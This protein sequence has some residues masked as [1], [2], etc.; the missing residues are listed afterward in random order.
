[1]PLQV[2]LAFVVLFSGVSSNVLFEPKSDSSDVAGSEYADPYQD[3]PSAPAVQDAEFDPQIWMTDDE[4]ALFKKTISKATKYFEF[5]CGGS[6]REAAKLDVP[7][8]TS[9]DTSIEWLGIVKNLVGERGCFN[10]YD[11]DIGPTK[12]E[13]GMPIGAEWSHLW[14]LLPL[15]Y[16]VYGQ[17][18][19][20][21]LIDGR[22]RVAC[23]M[24][25]WLES[26]PT[27]TVMIHDYQREAYHVVEQFYNKV[28]QA[29]R[30][31]VLKPKADKMKDRKTRLLALAKLKEAQ[32]DRF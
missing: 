7:C 16:H 20:T 11:V 26:E 13:L 12:K 23:A 32:S 27:V 24:V 29:N 19:D 14:P 2:A 18:S 30:L 3:E 5:G 8:I 9:V 4:V 6:T 1:M 28:E 31:V 10:M 25:V 21:V 22:L 17:G 15:S